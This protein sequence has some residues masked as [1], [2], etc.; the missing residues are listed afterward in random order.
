MRNLVDRLALRAMSPRAR[1]RLEFDGVDRERRRQ[2]FARLGN[3]L[4]NPFL[5]TLLEGLE[6]EGR[7]AEAAEIRAAI[8]QEV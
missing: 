8:H 4:Q 3:P 1:A 5:P 2:A 7:H 6:A